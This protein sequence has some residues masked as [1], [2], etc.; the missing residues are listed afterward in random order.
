MNF[1]DAVAARLSRPDML[2]ATVLLF[3]ALGFTLAV[4][5]PTGMSLVNEAWFSLAPVRTSALAFA[6]VI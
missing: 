1:L 5:W 6:A 4:G 2:Q 3:V